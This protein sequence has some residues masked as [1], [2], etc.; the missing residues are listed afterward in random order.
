[1]K[2]KPIKFF[3]CYPWRAK[4]NKGFYIAL[5]TNFIDDNMTLEYYVD[6]KY[7][8][9]DLKRPYL[10]FDRLLSATIDPFFQKDI[11]GM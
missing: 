9:T 10:S 8:F 6:V 4:E 3:L 2:L 1:M 5:N 11:A 7:P